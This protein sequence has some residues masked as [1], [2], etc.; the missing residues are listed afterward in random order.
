MSSLFALSLSK[1]ERRVFQQPVRARDQ[2]ANTSVVR[3]KERTMENMNDPNHD[4]GA[5]D[6]ASSAANEDI[7]PGDYLR[8]VRANLRSG[9]LKE[10]YGLLLQATVQYPDDPLILSYFGC[11]QAIVDKKYRSG[12]E[13]CKRAI[14]LL[15][16][17]ETFSEEILLPVFYLNLG[18]AFVAAGK[19]KDAI[20]SFKK[21][22]RFDNGNSDLRK[23]LQ[24]LG[25]R[26]RPPVP[27][28]DRSNPINRYIGLVLH[29]AKG[30][31]AGG[32]SGGR[33]R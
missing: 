13:A 24:K 3:R 20:D 26:K 16:K 30:T 5:G 10:A 2:F 19:K 21:G 1:G 18:R 32:K 11:F 6:A 28:L 7:K 17:K 22:L 8:A 23:E 25:V 4:R 31:Q 9:K 29:K 15:K 14:V 12:V 33:A 27:F